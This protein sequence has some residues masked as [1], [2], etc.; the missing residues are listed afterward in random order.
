MKSFYNELI[1]YNWEEVKTSIYNKTRDDV[2]NAL[3][4][5]NPTAEDFKALISP[6]ADSLLEQMAHISMHK[7]QK[8]FGKTMQLYIPLYLSNYCTNGCVYCGF[9]HA[10]KLERKILS[11]DELRTEIKYIRDIGFKHILLVTG[12]DSRYSNV[13][14]LAQMMDSIKDDFANI[15]IEVQPLETEEY[16]R[17]RDYKL[18]A[19][20]VYQETYNESRYKKYHPSGKKSDFRYRLE[21]PDRACK[22]GV[23]KV[24]LGALLGL[25][26]WRTEAF[27]IALHLQYLEKNYWQSKY[28]ISFPRLR[29]HTGGFEPNYPVSERNLSQLLFAYRIF[30][31]QVE[32]SLST[33]ESAAYR[34][35]ILKL[36]PTIYSAGSKTN[37]GGYAA[38]KKS[39]EQWTVNDNR[40]TEMIANMIKSHDYEVVWK[41]WDSILQ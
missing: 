36:G 29:P 9:N 15:S 24:G 17:L 37:P 39:L 5:E 13:D 31:E 11:A 27:F 7:T 14:Y 30:D 38:T 23:H 6:A 35:N 40:P 1:K 2:L 19:V 21:T 33:R 12:E 8:R 28:S 22:A 16:A 32:L 41:D 4:K 34:D 3:S 18:N 10:N 25:E 20:Y 26:D